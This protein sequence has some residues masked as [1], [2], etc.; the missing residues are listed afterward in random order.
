MTISVEEAA[1]RLPEL[2]Q[3]LGEGPITLTQDD[4]AVA[5]I[6]S[7]EMISV[8]PRQVRL[9]TMKGTVLYM[10]PD[11]DAPLDCFREYMP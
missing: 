5:T 7:G 3:N 9:G 6:I 11:F 10:A 2:L 4:V 8:P 1:K